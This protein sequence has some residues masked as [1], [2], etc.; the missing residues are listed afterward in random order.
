MIKAVVRFSSGNPHARRRLQ[1]RRHVGCRGCNTMTHRKNAL[2]PAI[3]RQAQALDGLDAVEPIVR[4]VGNAS[5]VL[6]GEATHGTHELYRLRAE[7]SKRL[8]VYKGFD[9][10]AVEADWP[11]ALQASR[12]A[13]GGADAA[14]DAEA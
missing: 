2:I 5:V 11:D 4:R 9:A 1:G 10:V 7:I 13:Q 8:I 14:P 3:Q 12:H 6:L